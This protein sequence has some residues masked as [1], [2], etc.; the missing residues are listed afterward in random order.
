MFNA[1]TNAIVQSWA[2][3]GQDKPADALKA[4]DR[5]AGQMGV[6]GLYAYHKAL[7]LDYF[8]PR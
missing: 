5:L 7:L 8:G 2:L 1:L 3:A 4:I 6:E